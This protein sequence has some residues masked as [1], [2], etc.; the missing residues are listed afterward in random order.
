MVAV[1]IGI[2]QNADLAV[3]QILQITRA[4]LDAKATAMS[5]TS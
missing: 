1:G 5:W 4:R 2:R 3:T